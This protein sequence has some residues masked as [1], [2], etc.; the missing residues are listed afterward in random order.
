MEEENYGWTEQPITQ[1]TPP[2][3]LGN[4]G[5]GLTHSSFVLILPF[6]SVYTR[7]FF[8]I[9]PGFAVLWHTGD[10]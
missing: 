5:S 6:H 9:N 10:K 4:I 2:I 7:I 1:H 8:Y 3:F